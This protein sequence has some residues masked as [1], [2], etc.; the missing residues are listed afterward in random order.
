MRHLNIFLSV[1]F[2]LRH[3]LGLLGYPQLKY[4]IYNIKRKKL[5]PRAYTTIHIGVLDNLK[6]PS[7]SSSF[8]VAGVLESNLIGAREVP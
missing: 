6:T 7:T 3:M 5:E 4:F 8:Y 2:A 1:Y